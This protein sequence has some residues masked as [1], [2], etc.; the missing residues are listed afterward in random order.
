[1]SSTT[2][3]TSASEV[4]LPNRLRKSFVVGN[5]DSTIAVFLKFE[6]GTGLTV[7][8]TDHDHRLGAGAGLTIN[9][10]QDGEESVKGRWTAVAASGTP[11]ISFFETED[12][13]R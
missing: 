6:R 3:T 10:Q 4:L 9:I 12:V 2:L 5:E 8:T 11:R 13:R 1:M 7:S